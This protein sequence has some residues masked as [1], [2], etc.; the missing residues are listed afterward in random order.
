LLA[1]KH[2]YN[3]FQS[4]LLVRPRTHSTCAVVGAWPLGP[5]DG[6]VCRAASCHAR[7]ATY[8]RTRCIAPKL[9]EAGGFPRRTDG[10]VSKGVKVAL[11]KTL[12]DAYMEASN[13]SVWLMAA[14]EQ[15]SAYPTL[16]CV[17]SWV[18]NRFDL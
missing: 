7:A 8:V 11:C 1:T 13:S 3:R 12:E 9:H 18:I 4:A 15:H 5:Q 14:S 6:Q 10:K 2:V 16:R 17:L